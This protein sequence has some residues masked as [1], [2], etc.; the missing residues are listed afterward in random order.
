MITKDYLRS[1]GLR[2]E[3][4]IR[5][6]YSDLDAELDIIRDEFNSELTPEAY[7]K[8]ADIIKAKHGDNWC[9]NPEL[10]AKALGV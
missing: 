8:I 1:L 3:E 10:F 7:A 5:E 4:A 2:F 9:S 6:D